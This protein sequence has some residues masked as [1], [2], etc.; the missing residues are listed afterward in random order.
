M[1]LAVSSRALSKAAAEIVTQSYLKSFFLKNK[2][3]NIA[4]VRSGNCIGGGDWTKDR[5]VKDCAESFLRNKKLIIRSPKATRPW[6][7]VMEPLFG[8]LNLAEKLYHNKKFEGAWNFGPSKKSNFRVIDV[9]KFGKKFLN[10]KSKILIKKKVYYESNYLSLNSSKSFKNL[11][12]KTMMNAEEALKL[13]FA[14]YKNYEDKTLRKKIIPF[15][16]TQIK[17]Y[18]EKL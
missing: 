17:K 2:I 18:K 13:T 9:A 8:Y 6:Q 12:W 7:H 3:C 10:S 15:T 16:L 1:S 5:I 4:T 11:K 14:W